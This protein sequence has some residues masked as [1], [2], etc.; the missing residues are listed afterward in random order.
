MTTNLWDNLDMPTAW[1][2]S[3]LKTIWKGKGSKNDPSKYR[4]LSI[5]STVCKLIVSIIL[6]RLRPWYEAQLSDEQNG[7][8]Q[9]RGT[10][11]GIYT[12]KRVQQITNRKKQPLYLLFVDLTAAFDH[13]PRKW[14]FDSIRLR[15]HSAQNQR[16]VDILEKLYQ[17]T[18]LTF[19]EAKSTFTTSSGVRQGGP[20]S[21]VL[22]NLYIDFVMRAFMEQSRSINDLNFFEHTYR[23]N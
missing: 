5:G 4:G 14:L 13:I 9:N 6:N 21:P 23:I 1:E 20:E 19:N 7:F 8:R 16:L 18:S 15:F 12:V 22:F 3:R 11:D 17:N 2:N 10:T